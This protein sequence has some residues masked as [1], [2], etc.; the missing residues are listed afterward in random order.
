MKGFEYKILVGNKKNSFVIEE[1]FLCIFYFVY[2]I[3]LR[4]YNL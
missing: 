1:F 4:H 3:D 2:S